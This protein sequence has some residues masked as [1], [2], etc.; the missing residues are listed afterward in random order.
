MEE[1]AWYVVHTQTGHE[2]KVREKILLNIEIQGFG[3]RVFQVLVPTEEVVEV[4]QNKKILR[5]RKFFPGY[6]LVEMNMTSEAY[7]FIKNITG[8]TGFLGDPNPVPLPEEEIAGIVELTDNTSGKPKHVVEFERG[9]SVRI[10]EGPFK[11]FIGVV[12]EVNEQKNKLK[13]MVTVFDRAAPVEL[14]FLQVEK[15]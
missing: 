6:V 2:D 14:D 13:V 4:K 10:T 3:D 15:N 5:K 9:E 7:W 8:V 12:E 1:K 11:H